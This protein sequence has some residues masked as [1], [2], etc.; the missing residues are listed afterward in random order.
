MCDESGEGAQQGGLAGSGLAGDAGE[1]SGGDV[2]IEVVDDGPATEPDA[3]TDGPDPV[4]QRESVGGRRG[5]GC[6]HVLSC[7]RCHP[8]SD[9][10][11][12]LTAAKNERT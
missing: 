10:R 11:D 3:D 7:L 5:G 6:R 1:L 8:V 4:A 12:Q 2:Q 9:F